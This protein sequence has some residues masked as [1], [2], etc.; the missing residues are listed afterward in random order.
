MS[1]F[2]HTPELTLLRPLA[3]KIESIFHSKLIYKLVNKFT[4]SSKSHAVL[5]MCIS[6]TINIK[7]TAAFLKLWDM[8]CTPRNLIHT[9][10][11]TDK[12]KTISDDHFRRS[13]KFSK[14]PQFHS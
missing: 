5:S 12:L 7:N 11:A 1:Y 9:F 2:N 6:K 8:N 10:S 14:K 3:P 13:A 4:L